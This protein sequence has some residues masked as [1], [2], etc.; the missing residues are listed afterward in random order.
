MGAR[1]RALGLCCCASVLIGCSLLPIR[2]SGNVLT[3]EK[4]LSGF[5]RV[6]AGWGF[7][8][9]VRQGES[10]AVTIQIDDNLERYL[11]AEV[12]GG[13]LHLGLKNIANFGTGSLRADVTMPE[14]VG[15]NLSGGVTATFSGFG[16]SRDFAGDFSGASNAT[17]HG[18]AGDLALGVGGGADVDM[19]DFVVEDARIE[20]SGGADV[21][22]NVS[23]RLNVEATGGANVYYLGN[24]TLGDIESSGGG[25][26]KRR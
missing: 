15:V 3:L 2:G 13:V 14:L 5:N 19:S 16:S 6:D 7:G 4:G 26:V 20:A 8:L 22:V 1:T 11:E 21:V 24:P 23:G 9:D 17:F 18:S 12:R 10:F 25:S